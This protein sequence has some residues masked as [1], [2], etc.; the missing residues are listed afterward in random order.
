M[1]LRK[2]SRFLELVP[3]QRR[4]LF[5]A[6]W[7]LALARLTTATAPFRQ[8]AA[9]LGE[10]ERPERRT[11]SWDETGYSASAVQ[12]AHAVAWAV[13]CAARQ[14]PFKAVCLQQAVAAKHMLRQRGVQGV[15]HFGVAKDGDGR[16][17]LEIHAWLDAAGVNV[18]GYP[19]AGR[20]VELACFV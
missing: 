4:L 3:F 11:I 13:Q 6:A 12:V 5:E 1:T 8:L 19:L 15:V 18:T 20:Y 7:R 16:D 10:P 9:D 14:V 17:A 2:L